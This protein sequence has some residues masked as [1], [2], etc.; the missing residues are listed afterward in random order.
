MRLVKP[1]R[2]KAVLPDARSID[3][4]YG[5]EPLFEPGGVEADESAGGV[6]FASIE[7]PYCGEPLETRLD[8]SEGSTCYIEDCQVCCRPMQLRLTVD[9]HG[10]LLELNVERTD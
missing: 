3:A 4:A 1:A 5:L 6:R 2:P 9:P 8:L 7:C 10:R